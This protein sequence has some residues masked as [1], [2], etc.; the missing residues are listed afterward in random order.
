M[1]AAIEFFV[2]FVVP[3]SENAP[4]SFVIVSF[5]RP[6]LLTEKNFQV[7]LIHYCCKSWEQ[8]MIVYID[9]CNYEFSFNGIL[10]LIDKRLQIFFF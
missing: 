4:Y 9:Q 3:D 1:Y 5:K 2:R 10:T 7:I 8:I 6:F